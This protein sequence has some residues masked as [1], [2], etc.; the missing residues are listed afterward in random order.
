MLSILLSLDHISS[1]FGGGSSRQQTTGAREASPSR[2]KPRTEHMADMTRSHHICH[3]S[4]KTCNI[5]LY[6]I[7]INDNT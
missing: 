7:S 5:D 1:A 4:S 6:M 3:V 2:P